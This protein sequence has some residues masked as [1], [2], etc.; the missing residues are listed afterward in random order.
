MQEVTNSAYGFNSS[1]LSRDIARRKQ[2]T[3]YAKCNDLYVYA[4]RGEYY[5][6]SIRWLRSPYYNYSNI[7]KH[8]HYDGFAYNYPYNVSNARDGVVP[9]LKIQL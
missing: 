9:A 5:G 6:N 7:A 1:F 4:S 3:D 2:G 8:I